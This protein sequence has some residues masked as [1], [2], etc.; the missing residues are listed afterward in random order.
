MPPL[1]AG[2]PVFGPPW[3]FSRWSLDVLHRVQG[4]AGDKLGGTAA[5][6]GSPAD[7]VPRWNG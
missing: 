4:Q 7:L 5:R 3:S 2:I 6:N 1:S